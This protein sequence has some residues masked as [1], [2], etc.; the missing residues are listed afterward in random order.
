M[1]VG[2]PTMP[3]RVSAI[4]ATP[5][6][7]LRLE[8]L[9]EAELDETG[10]TDDRRFLLVDP[11]DRIITQREVGALATIGARYE[12][13]TLVVTLPG[14]EEV[15][16]QPEVG[17]A[18]ETSFYGLR[19]A[20]NLVS[21]PWGEAISGVAGKELRLIRIEEGPSLG[22]DQVAVSLLAEESLAEFQ[23][24]CDLPGAPEPRRF[25]PT[26]LLA[27]GAPHEEDS[28]VGQLVQAG[29]AVLR[30]DRLDPRCSLTTRNPETG[31][32]DMDTLRL[33]A[34]YRPPGDDKQIYFGVYAEVDQP[35]TVRVGDPVH[36]L[37]EDRA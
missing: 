24:R 13:G 16:G 37:T 25:R 36:P 4:H 6:K 8:S 3:V 2:Y 32:R 28:W 18:Y 19:M 1:P 27:G 5:I 31:E 22:K 7:S 23:R 10:V 33:I 20:G 12:A 9:Q 11:N 35:G 26:L 17:A 14:G 15:S 21:G 30:I 34:S 29:N